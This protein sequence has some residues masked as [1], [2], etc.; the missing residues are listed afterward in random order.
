M[1]SI[2]YIQYERSAF[3]CISQLNCSFY[4]IK[5][6]SNLNLSWI[7]NKNC[8]WL[9]CISHRERF[10]IIEKK[11]IS[12][13]FPKLCLL[14]RHQFLLLFDLI[15]ASFSAVLITA[16]LMTRAL[17]LPTLFL[18]AF[19]IFTEAGILLVFSGFG[20]CSLAGW[21]QVLKNF[22]VL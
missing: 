8:N 22:Y 1:N 16:T 3:L 15:N 7:I 10:V 2:N 11:S 14:N 18:V 12:V 6:K 5:S 20:C 17:S 21:L 9:L 4:E 13:L 19:F